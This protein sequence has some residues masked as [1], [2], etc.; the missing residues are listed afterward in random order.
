MTRFVTSNLICKQTKDFVTSNDL[1]IDAISF[2]VAMLP[3]AGRGD[4]ER[5]VDALIVAVDLQAMS[6][7]EQVHVIQGDITSVSD[8]FLFLFV[9]SLTIV[10]FAYS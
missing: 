6:A 5:G 7:I 1:L 10:R 2:A 3:V 8:C 9:C 4:S